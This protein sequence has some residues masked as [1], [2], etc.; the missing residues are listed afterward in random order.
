MLAVPKTDDERSKLEL[1]V[2]VHDGVFHLDEV[3]AVAML[4]F[5]FRVTV[6]RSRLPQVWEKN[7]HLVD[8]GGVFDPSKGMY[9]HHQRGF[10][11]TMQS[12]GFGPFTTK[13]SSAGL[14]YAHQ[15]RAIISA[16]APNLDDQQVDKVYLRVY[17]KLIEAIDANDNGIARYEGSLPTPKFE[18]GYTKLAAIV[19]LFNA[20]DV[21]G[22]EQYTQFM[23]AVDF[24][25][26]IFEMV[27]KDVI[28]TWLPAVA[29]VTK[30][31]IEAIAEKRSYIL[32]ESFHPFQE[33]VESIPGNESL[34]HV[35]T[36]NTDRFT[37]QCLTQKGL[38]FVNRKSLCEAWRGLNG[39]ALEAAMKNSFSSCP[40]DLA[41]EGAIFVHATGFIGAH[42]TLTGAIC[43]AV[44]SAKE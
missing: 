22:I 10:N 41:S 5:P 43:M 9:D 11:E 15:G 27:V 13:L 36:K 24:M 14:I 7:S 21:N 6:S 29:V 25:R 35:I 39:E 23:T 1:T 12:L 26:R 16:I 40:V 8:V 30:A 31:T 19:S 34:L 32:L 44:M 33:I 38:A 37:I 2:C 17:A 3:T 20:E 18:D 28:N 4:T 42:K